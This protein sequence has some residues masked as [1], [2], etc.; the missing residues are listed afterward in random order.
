MQNWWIIED[1]NAII[2]YGL[3]DFN[4]FSEFLTCIEPLNET[5]KKASWQS[6]LLVAK[7]FEFW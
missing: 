6:N 1:I 5:K 2:K 3:N 7:L 4:D